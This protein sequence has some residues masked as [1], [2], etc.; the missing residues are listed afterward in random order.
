[1]RS[2]RP[3]LLLPVL[4]VPLAA[5][6]A[7]GADD[8]AVRMSGHPRFEPATVE[9]P[10]GGTVTWHNDGVTQHTVTAVDGD[11]DPTGAF[12]SGVVEGTGTFAHTF[13]ETGTHVYRCT[14]HG[15]NMVGVVSVVDR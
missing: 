12:D 13:D 10:V 8:A 9:V 6:A 2:R 5:C 7:R 11:G 3:R 15:G 4:L 1:M 14:I